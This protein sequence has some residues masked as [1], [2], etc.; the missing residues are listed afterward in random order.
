MALGAT[1]A[2]S[3][4][5]LLAVLARVPAPPVAVPLRRRLDA[6]ASPRAATLPTERARRE[7]PPP[8]LPPRLSP[9]LPPAGAAGGA[10]DAVAEDA[11]LAA[12]LGGLGRG[13]GGALAPPRPRTDAERTQL[14]DYFCR[15]AQRA[16]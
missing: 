14:Y 12:V 16:P 9:G 7:A 13:G 3:M 2:P 15:E 4:E 6:G 10:D 1:S 11:V 5:A 8:P